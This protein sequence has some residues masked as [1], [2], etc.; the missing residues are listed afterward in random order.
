MQGF[1][2]SALSGFEATVVAFGGGLGKALEAADSLAEQGI[3]AEVIDLRV[4][5]PLDEATVLESV[6]RTHRAVVVDE[7]WRSG[8]LAAEVSARIAETAF[9]E[10]DAPVQRVCAAEV[11]VPYARQLEEAALPQAADIVAAAQRVVGTHE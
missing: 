6:A 2:H 10:L 3:S 1:D 11:P 4:L 9:Y 8:S 7:A 5:R